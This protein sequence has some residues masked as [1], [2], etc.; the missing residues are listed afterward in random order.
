MKR[1]NNNKQDDDTYTSHV[2]GVSNAS[3]LYILGGNETI[4][5]SVC[6]EHYAHAKTTF[7]KSKRSALN[8]CK[9]SYKEVSSVVFAETILLCNFYTCDT[10]SHETDSSHCSVHSQRIILQMS[11]RVFSHANIRLQSSL[12]LRKKCVMYI[13]NLSW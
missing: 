4:S 1:Y 12:V 2:N 8:L 3:R 10:H 6:A 11:Y 13:L 5:D 9:S 7:T